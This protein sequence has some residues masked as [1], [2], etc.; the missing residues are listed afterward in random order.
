MIKTLSPDTIKAFIRRREYFTIIKS[1]G[2]VI[3]VFDG[4]IWHISDSMFHTA[5]QFA[6]V[7]MIVNAVEEVL[8]VVPTKASMDTLVERLTN[9]RPDLIWC[10]E[11]HYYH[12]DVKECEY[13]D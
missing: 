11:C 6:H 3:A 10:D 8:N 9:K 1:Y 12:N 2:E 4:S 5:N 13:N 7:N